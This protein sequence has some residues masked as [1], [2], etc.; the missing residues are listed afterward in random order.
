MVAHNFHPSDHG[1]DREETK[2]L[3]ANDTRLGKLLS[4]DVA[5]RVENCHGVV[6]T[7][8]GEE[9]AGVAESVGERCEVGLELGH[10]TS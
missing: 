1:A 5:S 4:V 6:G 7:D 10:G 3:G 2:N 9:C 8:S